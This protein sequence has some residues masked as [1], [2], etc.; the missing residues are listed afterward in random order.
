MVK[1]IC[2]FVYNGDDI[3][4]YYDPYMRTDQV[5]LIT[6]ARNP[7]SFY[8][9]PIFINKIT[10]EVSYPDGPPPPQTPA[11]RERIVKAILVGIEEITPGFLDDKIKPLIEKK[12]ESYRSRV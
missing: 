5:Y 4:V 1:K 8:V 9:G 3:N 10:G 12:Y 6:R 7:D 11:D 2:A